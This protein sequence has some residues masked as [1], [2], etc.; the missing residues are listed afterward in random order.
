MT[1]RFID[2]NCFDAL[3]LSA[4]LELFAVLNVTNYLRGRRSDEMSANSVKLVI[5]EVEIVLVS[6]N[7]T[8]TFYV[9]QFFKI[10]KHYFL[11]QFV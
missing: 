10:D 8:K 7:L 4:R 5:V 11:V 2:S 9:V 1:Y 6:Y 3:F